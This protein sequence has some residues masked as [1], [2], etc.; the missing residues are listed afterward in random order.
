MQRVNELFGK[1]VVSQTNGEKQGAVQ[2]IVFDEKVSNIVALLVGGFVGRNRV[3][4]WTSIASV[5]DMV[6]LEGEEALSKLGEDPEASDL[7][8]KSHKITGTDIVTQEGEK[9]GEVRDLFVNKRG[10][11]AGYE[12][13]RGRISDVRGRKFLPMEN[14]RATGKDTIIV[15]DANLL[16][17]EEAEKAKG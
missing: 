4:R 14:V 8:Q 1:E 9:I 2:D 5:G 6:V 7:R 13:S 17:V 16:P 12:V 10:Q 11:V 15:S 3:V